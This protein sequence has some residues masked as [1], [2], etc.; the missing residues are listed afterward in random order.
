MKSSIAIDLS[1]SCGVCRALTCLSQELLGNLYFSYTVCNIC[2]IRR[3][4]IVNFTTLHQKK[5]NVWKKV[6]VVKPPFT[7]LKVSDYSKFLTG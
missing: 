1:S 7:T 2:R 4:A 6:M 3:H 5:D